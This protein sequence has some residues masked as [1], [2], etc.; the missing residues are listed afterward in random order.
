MPITKAVGCPKTG[1]RSLQDGPRV[2]III[3]TRNS[4]ETIER[5]LKSIRLQTYPNIVTVVVDSYSRDETAT[6]A[7]RLGAQV[8]LLNAERS[9]ARNYGVDRS[10]EAATFVL[11]IDSDMELTSTVVEE[12]VDTST[13][14]NADAIIIPEISIAQDIIGEC[15]VLEKELFEYGNV[16]A[17][18]PKFFRRNIFCSIGGFDE[19]LVFGEHTEFDVRLREANCKIGKIKSTIFHHEGALSWKRFVLEKHYYGKT[20][21]HLLKRN[22]SAFAQRHPPL[23]R[24]MFSRRNV[25]LMFKHPFCLPILALMETMKYIAFC[26]GLLS[27]FV[28]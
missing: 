16:F 21:P 23:P 25:G 6:V 18:I 1:P 27:Y 19:D 9:A 15:R 24:H 7:G 3:P 28:S 8:L 14:L 20:A 13:M 12:C 4:Q 11:F 22:L 10:D 5:C 2:A 26:A 17:E